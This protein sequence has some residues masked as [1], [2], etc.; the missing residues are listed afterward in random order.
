MGI[1]EIEFHPGYHQILGPF[2]LFYFIF[3]PRLFTKPTQ[4]CIGPS[5]RIGRE[6]LCLPYAGF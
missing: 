1:N 2:H 3:V 4:K 5:I 6:N